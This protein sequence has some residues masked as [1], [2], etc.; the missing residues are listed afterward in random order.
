MHS[1][2]DTFDHFPIEC[3]PTLNGCISRHWFWKR[4]SS[5]KITEIF[6]AFPL[7]PTHPLLQIIIKFQQS[8]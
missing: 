1:I 2:D 5:P 8:V 4:L 7:T 3:F 6:A